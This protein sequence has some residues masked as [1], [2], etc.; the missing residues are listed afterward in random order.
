[1]EKFI[2]FIEQKFAPIAGKIAGQRHLRALQSSFLTLVGYM[3]LGSFAL[4]LMSPI[5]DYTKMDPGFAQNFMHAWADF[6][7]VASW[8]LTPI[9]NVTSGGLSLYVCIGIA[10]FLSK[11]YKFNSLL[12]IVVTV[13]SFLI[14]CCVGK[15]HA[16]DV[17]YIST[18]G[19]FCAI[20][21]SIATMEFYR[22]L[23]EKKVGYIDLAKTGCPDAIADSIG[24]LAPVLIILL[25]TSTLSAI[26]Q[27]YFN[28]T[29]PD[30]VGTIISPISNVIDTPFGFTLIGF[31]MCFGFWFGIH[32]GYLTGPIDA[33]LYANLG[34]NMTAYAAGTPADQLPYIVTESFFWN[35]MLVG[36]TCSVVAIAVLCLFSKSEQIKTIGR[37]GIVPSLFNIGEPIIYGLPL[38]YNVTMLIPMCIVTPLDGLIFYAATALGLVNRTMA[39]PGWNMPT[40][41]G[42]FLAT[43]D[44]RALVLSVLLF[45]LNLLIWYPFIKSYEKQKLAEEAEDRATEAA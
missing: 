7:S 44:W 27:I 5:M 25:T 2:A 34:A 42:Q 32:D 13:A 22:F 1:M 11:R 16:L 37:L 4:L 23:V 19:M 18:G 14:A 33:F 30:L 45:G 36:G 6:A 39:Y 15:D 35:C 12:P 26:C 17:S 38:A 20:V 41:F 24:N 21:L 40:P 29:L 9:Y 31:L 28:V 10:F 3:T 43:M 8:V